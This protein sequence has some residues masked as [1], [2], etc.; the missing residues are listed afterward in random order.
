M[1]PPKPGSQDLSPKWS[2]PVD[3]TQESLD[4]AELVDNLS[5]IVKFGSLKA[6]VMMNHMFDWDGLTTYRA[7]SDLFHIPIV[8]SGVTAYILAEHKAITR[9]VLKAAGVP[10]APGEMLRKGGKEKTTMELPFIVKPCVEGNSFGVSLCRTQEEVAPAIA[11]AFDHDDEILVEK[12][13][14]LGREFRVAVMETE[15]GNLRVLPP[16]EYGVNKERQIRAVF[17]KFNLD[18]GGNLTGFHMNTKEEEKCPA[19]VDD[20]LMAKFSDAVTKAHRA[21]DC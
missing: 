10:V 3:L 7:I 13:I 9:D 14:P 21:L 15:E 8:G 19:D 18:K 5:G 4:K 12:F 11:K 16:I 17:D 1:H 6:D 20:Q 2:F